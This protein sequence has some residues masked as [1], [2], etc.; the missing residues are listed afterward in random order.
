MT[1]SV[2]AQTQLNEIGPTSRT[3]LETGTQTHFGGLNEMEGTRIYHVQTL[4]HTLGP[5]LSGVSD[6]P[7]LRP[8]RCLVMTTPKGP[9]LLGTNGDGQG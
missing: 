2:P 4:K 7:G 1:R 9:R 6:V 8:T 5:L 3:L